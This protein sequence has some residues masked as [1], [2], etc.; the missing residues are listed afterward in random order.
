MFNIAFGLVLGY[1][2]IIL[3][4]VAFKLFTMFIAFLL[5]AMFDQA[6]DLESATNL[7]QEEQE[8]GPWA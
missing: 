1:F 3:V 8:V 7:K 6:R 5:V 4:T 2:L